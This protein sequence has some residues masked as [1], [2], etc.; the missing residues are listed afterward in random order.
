MFQ[1]YVLVLGTRLQVLRSAALAISLQWLM[2]LWLLVCWHSGR[3]HSECDS[4]WVGGR[5]P[6]CC[7]SVGGR[8]PQWRL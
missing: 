4:E 7:S 1:S 3:W 8:H 2:L 6:Q 5:H